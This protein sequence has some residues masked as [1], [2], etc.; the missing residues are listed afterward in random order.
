MTDEEI[1]KLAEEI[2]EQKGGF[3]VDPEDHYQQHQRLDK[4]LDLY[5]SASN[6]FFKTLV[7]AVILGLFTVAALGLGWHK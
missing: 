4:M 5:D 3:Y 2:V 1:K 6:I 7:G